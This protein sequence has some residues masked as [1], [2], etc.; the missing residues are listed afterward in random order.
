[1]PTAARSVRSPP[2]LGELDFLDHLFALVRQNSPQRRVTGLRYIPPESGNLQR[3]RV[4]ISSGSHYARSTSSSEVHKTEY[5]NG[6]GMVD[7]SCSKIS[8]VPPPKPEASPPP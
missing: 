4:V 7:H 3:G 6:H 1:M 2:D 8:L 5:H